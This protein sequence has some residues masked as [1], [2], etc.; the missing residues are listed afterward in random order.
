MLGGIFGSHVFVFGDHL[1]GKQVDIVREIAVFGVVDPEDTAHTAVLEITQTE[2]GNPYVL[3]EE[4]GHG[5]VVVFEQ[6]HD[7]FH[8]HILIE[9]AVRVIVGVGVLLGKRCFHS[10]NCCFFVN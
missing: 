8:S 4:R 3:F 7:G 5:S 6:L 1:T 10:C 2:V 9:L